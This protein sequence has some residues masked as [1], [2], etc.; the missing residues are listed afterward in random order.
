MKKTILVV[1][2]LLVAMAAH[3]LSREERIEQRL[4]PVG[5]SCMA[6]DPCASASQSAAAS[7]PQ[8]PETVYNTYCVGCHASGVG[9]APIVGDAD[10]WAPRIEKGLDA[11]YASG[12][13]GFGT[14]MPPKG[15]CA[16]CS[17]EDIQA[18]VD[19]MVESSQ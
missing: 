4:K 11:L 17:E 5:E 12:I 15:T 6:G 7:G 8:D 16:S 14:L 1:M 18:T 9:N 13:N 2:A 3:G 10:S 19:Y